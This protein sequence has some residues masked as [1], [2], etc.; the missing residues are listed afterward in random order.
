VVT[1]GLT[2]TG[3]FVEENAVAD[4]VYE[5]APKAVNVALLPLQMEDPVDAAD[6][7]GVGLT[8]II[9]VLVSVHP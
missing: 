7:V 8:V 4:Q 3:L 5:V 1:V 9:T 2:V 6:K